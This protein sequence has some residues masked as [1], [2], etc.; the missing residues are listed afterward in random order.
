M[1]YDTLLALCT[2]PMVCVFWLLYVWE[3]PRR[4]DHIGRSEKY[5]PQRYP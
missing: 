4:A 3:R 1:E 2:L 5:D